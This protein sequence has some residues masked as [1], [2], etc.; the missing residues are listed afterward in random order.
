MILLQAGI[1][2]GMIVTV[3]GGLLLLT[4]T[5]VLTYIISHYLSE[6]KHREY[7]VKQQLTGNNTQKPP[8]MY[9]FRSFILALL[10]ILSIIII[11][12]YAVL[13]L[14]GDLG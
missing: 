8:K 9:L 4:G 1:A 10:I 5:P 13:L 6:K 11:G 7:L 14:P 12:M 2:F 3:V